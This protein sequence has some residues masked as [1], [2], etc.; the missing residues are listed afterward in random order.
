MV[1]TASNGSEY[2][3]ENLSIQDKELLIRLGHLSKPSK[4][5]ALSV[6]PELQQPDSTQGVDTIK[7]SKKNEP[8]RL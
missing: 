8:T 5:T 7:K 2:D 6:V 1:I 3:L 4:D